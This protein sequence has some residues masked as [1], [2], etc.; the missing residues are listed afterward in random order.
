RESGV[1][2][3]RLV[4]GLLERHGVPRGSRVL[5]LG[6]GI[7]R[8]AVPL[9]VEGYRVTCL[10]I[11]GDYVERALEYAREMGVA[12]RFVGVVG[13]AWR[14][15]KLVEGGFDAVLMVWSTLLGY[16]ERPELDVELLARARRV[17]RDGGRLLVLRQI[18]RDLVAARVASC[19]EGPVLKDA[20]GDFV[21]VENPRFDPVSSLLD[22]VWTFYERG[23]PGLKLLGELPMRMRIYTVT[24]LVDLAGRAG[25]ELEALYGSLRGGPFLIGRSTFNGVFQ[26]V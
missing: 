20:G 19:G 23:G 9:A 24:E 4:A 5:E 1:E 12:G 13:D 15:D 14:V 21:V 7:G 22:N 18:N 3:A 8:I 10:D 26:A 2:E 6:C 17:V 11:S 25:W 16:R